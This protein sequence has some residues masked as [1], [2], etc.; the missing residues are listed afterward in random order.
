[1]HPPETEDKQLN[2]PPAQDTHAA[3]SAW[4]GFAMMCVG[5]FMAILD[6]QVV[7][8]SLP[9]IQA[10]LDIAPDQMSWVQTAYLIAEVI[11]IPLTGILTRAF[12]MRWLFV[13]AISVFALASIGCGTSQSFTGLIVWRI[14]QGFSGG[15]LI[16]AVFSAVFLLFPIRQQGLATTLGG[17]LAVLAPTIGPIVGGWITE[18]ISWHWLFFINVAPGIVSAVIA[19]AMLPRRA[20]SLDDLLSI[21]LVALASLAV[22]LAAFEIAL[23]EAPQRGWISGFSLSLI[24]LSATSAVLFVRRT[25]GAARPLADLTNFADR[26]FA[27]GCVLSFVLGIGLFG[28]VYLM[29]IF[30]AFVRAHNA[31]E[32]GTIMLVTGCAQL[33]MAPVAVVLEQ[34]VDARVL[35]GA[36]FAV[37]A[38]GLALSAGQSPQTDF[39]GMLWPQILRGSAIMFCLL[40]PTRLALGNLGAERVPDASGLFNLMRNLGGAMG[41]AMID[42]II[43]TRSPV[44]AELLMKQVQSGNEAAMRFV[45]LTPE[46]IASVASGASEGT[47]QAAIQPLI[48]TAALTAAINE[49]WLVV[50]VL[51]ALA[52]IGVPFARRPAS[53]G[54]P[55]VH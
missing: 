54:S 46:L 42:T 36:G 34:R 51:T 40:P 39:D 49:A 5:M 55:L 47:V 16:P 2:A 4:I 20:V 25:L 6:I 35:T 13:G 33:V 18:T 52:L 11:A 48:E 31:L 10:A 9:T 50:A 41:I 21:D 29:P 1:M 24:A 19:T 28:S 22:A 44:E 7:A 37:L 26:S 53:G 23:K 43:F 15:T 17:V 27:V 32:I 14:L 38:T 45:G 8:T 12:G 30:L 3:V